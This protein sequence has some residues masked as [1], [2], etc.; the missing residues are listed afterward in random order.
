MQTT[1]ISTKAT[2]APPEVAQRAM[3]SFASL[4]SV[5]A[6]KGAAA[7][8]ADIPKSDPETVETLST[9]PAETLRADLAKVEA[10]LT[11]GPAADRQE[12]ACDTALTM[13]KPAQNNGDLGG[14]A[15]AALLWESFRD[16]PRWVVQEG[17]RKACVALQWRPQP[18]EI[19][20][21]FPIGYRRLQAWKL[22]LYLALVHA[23]KADAAKVEQRR[24]DEE[25][26]AM[27][28]RMSE[29]DRAEFERLQESGAHD[30]ASRISLRYREPVDDL[31]YREPASDAPPIASGN[32]RP[33]NGKLGV[34]IRQLTQN[35]PRVIGAA[36]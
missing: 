25:R 17:V 28:A 34:S 10:M 6:G 14:A 35:L 36:R 26:E 4:P 19:E 2:Y 21:F 30:A 23:Q 31:R 16:L 5:T 9:L 32:V 29:E 13:G 33:V 12:F 27:F 15:Y 1:A 3:V 24:R 8:W 7:L 18:S 22:N 20:P 11:Y